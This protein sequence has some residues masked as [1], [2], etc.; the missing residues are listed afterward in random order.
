MVHAS[1]LCVFARCVRAS[2]VD[3]GGG[4]GHRYHRES[5][6]DV[7]YNPTRNKIVTCGDMCVK[8]VDMTTW[9]E[10]HSESMDKELG[11]IEQVAWAPDGSMVSVASRSGHFITYTGAV[12]ASDMGA[13]AATAAGAGFGSDAHSQALH[14]SMAPGLAGHK[15]APMGAA[16]VGIFSFTPFS[17]ALHALAVVVLLGLVLLHAIGAGP[18]DLLLL[19]DASDA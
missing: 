16:P 6:R 19:L 1:G 11:Q 15:S 7:A 10:V 8:I 14:F 9:K 3:E 18:A 5:F 2:G 12:L 17:C 13:A 4:V